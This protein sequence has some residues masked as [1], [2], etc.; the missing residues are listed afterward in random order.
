MLKIF[1]ENPRHFNIKVLQGSHKFISLALRNKTTAPKKSTLIDIFNEFASEPIKDYVFH[2]ISKKLLL[3]LALRI[4]Q[5]I[6]QKG[7]D[8]ASSL[9]LVVQKTSNGA[10]SVV[11]ARNNDKDS[12]A[13]ETIEGAEIED[14]TFTLKDKHGVSPDISVAIGKNRDP[15]YQEPDATGYFTPKRGPRKS[16]A[17]YF[18]VHIIPNKMCKVHLSPSIESPHCR[19][20]LMMPSLQRL[21]L[22][23]ELQ[24]MTQ[25]RLVVSNGRIGYQKRNDLNPFPNN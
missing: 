17:K 1:S 19:T 13:A 14:A 5:E 9:Q 7:V 10:K 21:Q 8:R 16:L 15:P 24:R 11:I 12:D 20:I 2:R 23:K 25:S 4:I 22:H 18:Q 6:V 3:E